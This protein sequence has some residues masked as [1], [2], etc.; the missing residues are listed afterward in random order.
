MHRKL[1]AAA[2]PLVL[3][4]TPALSET[5]VTIDDVPEVVL[6]T[7]IETAP[8]ATFDRISIEIEDGVVVYE[9]ESEDASG[10]HI[11]IDVLEDG[12]L[13]EIELE[14][15]MEETPAVVLAAM[16]KAT[17]GFEPTYI[18]ASVRRDGSFV[19]EFEGIYDGREIDVEIAEDGTVLK[20][21]DDRQS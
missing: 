16:D 17:P 14:M 2:A 1:M 19:Y 8:G 10:K 18:E 12:T 3:I 6:D 13:D 21:V 5:L 7:A 11:E 4:A 9:F 15:S 20:I